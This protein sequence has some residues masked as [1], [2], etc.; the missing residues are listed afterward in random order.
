VW[1]GWLKS[2]GGKLVNAPKAAGSAR[3]KAIEPA[4]GRYVKAK[5]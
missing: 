1:S 2:R 3:F 5:A 4:P